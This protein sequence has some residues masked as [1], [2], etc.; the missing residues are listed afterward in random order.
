MQMHKKRKTL[1]GILEPLMTKEEKERMLH[2]TTDDEQQSKI[3]LTSNGA[4][5]IR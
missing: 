4:R 5:P 2:V 3:E 1:A